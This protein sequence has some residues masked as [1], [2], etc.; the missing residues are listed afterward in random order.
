MA[1]FIISIVL[2]VPTMLLNGWVLVKLWLWFIVPLGVLAITVPHGIG[3]ASVVSYL[4]YQF[5]S[6]ND[7]DEDA[8]A[9][10]LVFGITKPIFALAFGYA[11]HSFM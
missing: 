8:W 5:D 9:L 4:T 3:I 2:V 10:L 7:A 11:V 6:R 1:K